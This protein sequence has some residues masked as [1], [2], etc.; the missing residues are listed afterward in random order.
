MMNACDDI[1]S[2][3]K[4]RSPGKAIVLRYVT[5]YYEWRDDWDAWRAALVD[6]GSAYLMDGTPTRLDPSATLIAQTFG[7]GFDGHTAIIRGQL[8]W[9]QVDAKWTWATRG[10]IVPDLRELD[11]TSLRVVRTFERSR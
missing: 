2:N 6:R 7:R 4:K 3:E 9:L 10:N 1:G 5:S 8:Q 11:N